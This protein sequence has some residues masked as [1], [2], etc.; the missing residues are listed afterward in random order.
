MSASSTAF[1][2]RSQPVTCAPQNPF[3]N[4]YIYPSGPY[5][6]GSTC[7]APIL[8]IR[9]PANI[10][11]VIFY[12]SRVP[13]E[14]EALANRQVVPARGFCLVSG[15]LPSL[16]QLPSKIRVEDAAGNMENF[17][18]THTPEGGYDVTAFD[19]FEGCSRRC[20]A[21]LDLRLAGDPYTLQVCGCKAPRW[22]GD[23]LV[24]L[25][26]GHSPHAEAEPS[27]MDATG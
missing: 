4:G 7:V 18:L 15:L 11:I 8:E 27:G 19:Y 3:V 22:T 23:V 16:P 26:V 13:L 17:V 9:N 1:P 12:E 10:P 24:P 21:G 2:G 6:L 5:A 25:R 20:P 14:E